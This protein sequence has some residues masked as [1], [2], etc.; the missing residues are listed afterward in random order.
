MAAEPVLQNSVGKKVNNST[1]VD[2][3]WNE[4]YLAVGV[5]T[6]VHRKRGTADVVLTGPIGN[7]V[8]MSST[9]NEGRYSCR[10]GVGNA[11]YDYELKKAFGEIIPVQE[12]AQVVVGFMKNSP[13][14]PVILSVLHNINEDNGADSPKN[15]LPDTVNENTTTSNKDKFRYTRISRTQD[16]F[17]IDG[18]GDFEVGNHARSFA[19]GY[20]S[21]EIDPDAFDYKD[22]TARDKTGNTVQL[23]SGHTSPMKFLAVFKENANEICDSVRAFFDAAKTSLRLF[24][25]QRSQNRASIIEID[26]Y[27]AINLRRV[28]DYSTSVMDESTRY[29]QVS[30]DPDGTFQVR[31]QQG[32]EVATQFGTTADGQ[33]DASYESGSYLS[34][35]NLSNN[36]VSTYTEANTT[37]YKIQKEEE[38][39]T[40]MM[41]NDK[42]EIDIT[43]TLDTP[44]VEESEKYVKMNVGATGKLTVTNQMG[45][46]KHTTFT[47][48]N[49][50]VINLTYHAGDKETKMVI[51]G[52][53]VSVT[54]E[55]DIKLKTDEK[56]TVDAKTAT[57]TSEKGTT[58]K[59]EDFDVKAGGDINM[60]AGGNVNIKGAKINLN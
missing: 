18:Y 5:V 1:R 7:G 19:A 27:G 6:Q 60:T 32:T 41:L 14:M 8:I 21:K 46:D 47:I 30:I 3:S 49:T 24:K 13:N 42:G 12:G 56:I 16:F 58:I 28:L 31:H 35:M 55:A 57:I 50:G 34:R 23:D 52:G 22:L 43:R 54:T 37:I 38:K 17:T 20:S 4:G 9:N 10:I 33:F 2:R 48:G 25:L 40:R 45:E 44:V 15:I 11:G 29:T 36:G 59:C 51:N 26:E 39:A 53:G